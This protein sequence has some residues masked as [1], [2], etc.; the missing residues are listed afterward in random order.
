MPRG[1]RDRFGHFRGRHIRARGGDS[2]SEIAISAGKVHS[3][4]MLL[5]TIAY[6]MIHL[7]QCRRWTS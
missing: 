3:T 4:D 6:E 5:A 1:A 2:F 7:Y